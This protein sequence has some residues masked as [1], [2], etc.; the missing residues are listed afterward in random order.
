MRICL[1]NDSQS[2]DD[3]FLFD[4]DQENEGFTSREDVKRQGLEIV[5]A[6]LKPKKKKARK[7]KT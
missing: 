3:E 4:H 6:M 5:N 2:D 1:N 7:R